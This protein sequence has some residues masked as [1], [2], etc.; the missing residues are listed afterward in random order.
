VD[1][2][3]NPLEAI[4][5]TVIVCRLCLFTEQDVAVALL[6]VFCEQDA[7]AV[8]ELRWEGISSKAF[9]VSPLRR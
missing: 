7:V 3:D 5:S 9:D 4:Y 1:F 2:T 6:H 8:A